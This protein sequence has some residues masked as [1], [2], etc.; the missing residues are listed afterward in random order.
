MRLKLICCDVFARLAYAAA[1]ESHHLV[2]IEL[3]PMLAHNEPD[4]LRQDLQSAIDKAGQFPEVYDKVIMAYGLCGNAAAGL[5]S[6]IPLIIPRMHDCCAMF[7]G[8]KEAF[9]KVF[10][11]RLS[12]RWRSCGYVERGRDIEGDY[13]LHPDFLKLAAEYDEDNAEYI[14]ETMHPPAES[15]EAVYIEL[16]GFEYGDTKGKYINQMEQTPDCQIEVVSG[17]AG[18]FKRLINGPWDEKDFLELLPGNEIEPI[19]DMVEVFRGKV[20]GD[21]IE[22]K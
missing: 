10:G 12:T 8:S 15:N 1:A 16:E 3:L 11:H 18:W 7:M 13:K 6:S 9:T 19:Y 4:R 21:H 14:W 20:E 2:D 5:T 22:K 17:D